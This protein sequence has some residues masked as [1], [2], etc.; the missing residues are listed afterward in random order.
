M[1]WNP[2]VICG[3]T[4]DILSRDGAW[5]G[6]AR[7]RRAPPLAPTPG[8]HRTTGLLALSSP[9]TSGMLRY[10]VRAL[11][12]RVDRSER[13]SGSW[14]VRARA[15]PLSLGVWH[16]TLRFIFPGVGCR[17]L[18]GCGMQSP[19]GPKVYLTMPE[20]RSNKTKHHHHPKTHSSPVVRR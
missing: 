2:H 17:R 3:R 16:F 20:Y 19:S 9:R 6:L 18:K 4:R 14:A 11:F 10:F 8:A 7:P 15:N 1:G 5:R 12:P 13:A